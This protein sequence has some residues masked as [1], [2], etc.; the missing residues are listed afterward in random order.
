MADEEVEPYA[1]PSD[2]QLCSYYLVISKIIA[3]LDSCVPKHLAGSGG[4]LLDVLHD[5]ETRTI[6][7]CYGDG[8]SKQEE[9]PLEDPEDKEEQWLHDEDDVDDEEELCEEVDQRV[10]EEVMEEILDGKLGTLPV[11]DDDLLNLE[12]P[13]AT[14]DAVESIITEVVSPDDDES[15]E[16]MITEEIIE[17][18]PESTLIANPPKYKCQYVGCPKTFQ[19]AKQYARHQEKV[20]PWLIESK[21]DLQCKYFSCE[22][23]SDDI[24]QLHI[25]HTHHR[26]KEKSPKPHKSIDRTPK[27]IRGRCCEYCDTILEPNVHN[28]SQHC[29]TEHDRTPYTCPLC[30]GALFPLQSHLA[31]HLR[32]LHSPEQLEHLLSEQLWRKF[33]IDDQQLAECRFCYRVISDRTCTLHAMR[34][35][36]ELQQT[37]DHCGEA[38]PPAYCTLQKPVHGSSWAKKRC[39]ECHRSVSTKSFKEHLATHTPERNFPCTVCKKTFKVRRNATR[40][41]QNHINANNR[42]RRCYDCGHVCEND[43]I[44]VEHYRAEHPELWPY[45]C[46]ICDA[47]F[48]EKQLLAEHCHAHTDAERQMVAVKN[49]V[50]SYTVEDARVYECTL[51][52]RVFTTKRATVAH[53]IVHTD[54]PLMCG[55]CSASFRTPNELTDHRKDMHQCYSDRER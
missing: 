43:T 28:Y 1:I 49:P 5:P 41:I 19:F 23:R 54:R 7:I 51:C 32:M 4:C 8:V 37:C 40:H 46:P 39:P 27:P 33:T 47:G 21:I 9:S 45:R 14:G 36:K 44:L 52:R 24:Q 50:V 48:H 22:V 12:S 18:S 53:T 25:H 6:Y 16:A 20:H 15:E 42:K 38:H 2:E 10:A 17:E 34:H 29:L 26:T 31:K 11:E 30:D 13:E 55:L 35:R 3:I